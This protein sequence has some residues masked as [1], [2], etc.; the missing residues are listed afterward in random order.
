MRRGDLFWVR[1]P[2]PAGT[3]P[4]VLVSRD[5]AY[6]VRTRVTVV[7]VTRT[8]RGIPTEV[9]L[10]PADGLP[11]AGAANADEIVTVPR[12]LLD[13]RISGLTRAKLAELDEAIRFA[14]GL[15]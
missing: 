4:A 9:R 2:Q 13:R 5:E 11:K 8:V 14:L 3:R 6:S 12:D 15:S 7:P 10:G 1:F